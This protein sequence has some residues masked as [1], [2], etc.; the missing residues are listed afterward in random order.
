MAEMLNMTDLPCCPF[1]EYVDRIVSN[2]QMVKRSVSEYLFSRESSKRKSA[3]ELLPELDKSLKARLE[4][5]GA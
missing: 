5:L 2:H 4:E 3:S 1:V